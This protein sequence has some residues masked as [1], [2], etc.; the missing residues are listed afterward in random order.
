MICIILKALLEN[1]QY[2]LYSAQCLNG[3]VGQSRNRCEQC[4]HC[5]A[6]YCVDCKADWMDQH[7]NVLC[8][9]FAQWKLD[10]EGTK[11]VQLMTSMRRSLDHVWFE[12]ARCKSSMIIEPP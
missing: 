3:F 10:N 4:E 5:H 9:K 12:C 8:A 2:K 7:A 11:S 1:P 6:K